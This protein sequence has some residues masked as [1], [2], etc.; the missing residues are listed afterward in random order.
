LNVLLLGWGEGGAPRVRRGIVV[1]YAAAFAAGVL[2]VDESFVTIVRFYA[3]VLLLGIVA[4]AWQGLRDTAWRWIAAGFA[5]SAVAALLQQAGVAPHP[6][7]FDH[8]ALYHVVQA[9]ALVLL[10][11]GFR[12]ADPDVG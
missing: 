8:N 9:A 5:L 4:A 12:R 10:Y 7:Y 3:P 1:V 11:A 6:V 2:F